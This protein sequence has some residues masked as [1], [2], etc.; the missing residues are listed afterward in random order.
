M[1]DETL[2]I[3]EDADYTADMFWLGEESKDS[4]PFEID[5]ELDMVTIDRTAT[6][7]EEMSHHFDDIFAWQADGTIYELRE[8]ANSAA[9]YINRFLKAYDEL[10]DLRY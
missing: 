7:I 10:K 1:Y 6:L 8:A 5:D 9:F 4:S 3:L 2:S